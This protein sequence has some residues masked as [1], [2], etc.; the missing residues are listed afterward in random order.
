MKISKLRELLDKKDAKLTSTINQCGEC[1]E[2]FV[3][4]EAHLLH[5]IGNFGYDK[6]R[7]SNISEMKKSMVKVNKNNICCWS[8]KEYA[9]KIENKQQSKS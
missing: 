1:G 7:C 2:L 9:D 5:R 8:S 6:R 4:E 3:S